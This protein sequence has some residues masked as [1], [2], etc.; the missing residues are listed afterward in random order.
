MAARLLGRY[1]KLLAHMKSSFYLPRRLYSIDASH[2]EEELLAAARYV[3]VLA[4]PG[5]GKTALMGS[6]AQQL[7]TRE[8]TASKFAHSSETSNNV[9]LVIDAF[10]ELAKFDGA[11]IYKVL[12]QASSANP[13]HLYLSS[14]SSEWGI[15]ATNIFEEC[16]AHPPLIVWLYEFSESEQ[17][18]IFEYHVSGEDFSAFRE[19]VARFDLE[20]LL[21]NPQFLKLFAGAYIESGRQF[22]DKR[23][24]FEQAVERLAKES[25]T[26]V[27]MTSSTLSIPQ[28]IDFSSK[29]FAT[30]L[31][32]GAEGV[33]KSEAA[34]DGMYPAL[35]SLCNG[36]IPAD[37]LLATQL[38]RPGENAD[39]HR[40]VHRIVAEYCAA[41]Y[42]TNRIIDPVDPLTR[43]NCLSIIAPNSTVREEL[44]GL[45]AW[46]AALGNK[47]V[48]DAA[49]KLDPFGVLVNG[50]P[51][52]L[53]PSSKRLLIQRLVAVEALDPYFRKGDFRR[54]FSASEFFN[55]D[56]VGEIKPLL[57][58][59]SSGHLRDLVLELLVDSTV[60]Y[61]LK[62]ELRQLALAPEEAESTRRLA[63]RCL[64]ISNECGQVNDLPCLLFEATST[65]L[66]ITAD[67]IKSI[68]PDIVDRM[69][70][71]GFFRLCANIYPNEK[72]F[73]GNIGARY[74]INCLITS[75]PLK[76][77]QWLLDE[78][79]RDLSSASDRTP[80][81]VTYRNGI[82]KV[83][84]SLLDQYFAVAHPPFNPAQIWRWINNLNYHEPMAVDG[85]RAVQ[86]LQQDDKLRQGIFALAFHGISDRDQV[87]KTKRLFEGQCHSGLL[88]KDSDAKWLVDQAF[89]ADNSVLW[90]S[91]L[92][93]P[94]IY[95]VGNHP[96]P[97]MLRRHMRE[98]ASKKKL[99]MR[100]FA[101]I[102]RAI[103]K[104]VGLQRRHHAWRTSAIRRQR[105]KQLSLQKKIAKHIQEKTNCR[106]LERDW[107]SC[108]C[109]AELVLDQ[110]EH[111]Q[112]DVVE[113]ELVRKALRNCLAFIAPHI[114]DTPMF[115]EPV[116]S[117][118]N[119]NALS[120][121][122]ASCLE[123]M[124]FK[125]S[126]E[127]VDLRLI[128]A[129]R[130]SFYWGYS[131]VSYEDDCALKAEAGRL[132]FT[133]QSS[134]ENYLRQYVEPQLARAAWV[135]PEVE[136]LREEVFSDLRARV[137][138]DWLRRFP[139]LVLS[140]TDT[141]FEIAAQYCNRQDLNEFITERCGEL[142]EDWK[143]PT[144]CEVDIND[145]QEFWLVRAWYFLEDAP[146]AFGIWQESGR[147]C[148][149]TLFE[150]HKR[151][152]LRDGRFWPKLTSK[153]AGKIMTT[154][155]DK[156]SEV[157]LS[158]EN[159]DWPNSPFLSEV[160]GAITCENPYD[161]LLVLDRLLEDSR[162]VQM[163]MSLSSL[164]SDVVSK[165]ALQAF[166][167]PAPRDIFAFL[168]R[169][170]IVTVEGLRQLVIQE[171]CNYQQDIIGG[172]YNP[173]KRFYEKGERLDEPRCT[174]I[175]AERLSLK[176]QS[177]NIDVIPEHQL[178]ASKRSDFT[179]GKLIRGK[180]R[181]LVTEVKGQW[182]KK[183]Y[184]AASDQLSRLYAIHPDAEQ[185]GIFLVIWFGPDIEVAGSKK[186]GIRSAEQLRLEIE[187]KLPPDLI[188]L[189]DVFVLDVSVHG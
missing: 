155:A 34:E 13:S 136:L 174:E 16:M 5:A 47:P 19:E 125:G 161:A 185:Q 36:N 82:S 110:P 163:H 52:Q 146:E 70:L 11:S 134:A 118:K 124:R 92:P 186:H 4:E 113:L 8:V 140:T 112:N 126:L 132:I 107:D 139:N 147:R 170:A 74:F 24:I 116:P 98:Q 138:I 78:L 87:I 123:I 160:L 119:Y 129:L 43:E 83:I 25:N 104:T 79:T 158:L 180:R 73:E 176:L 30:L 17:R 156:C 128:K 26:Q 55:R 59:E 141:L 76:E 94:E 178:H 93:Q 65:S 157:N 72:R 67:I 29:V 145:E 177:Q 171:L 111:F 127:S 85:S 173:G 168:D 188:G 148:V 135:Y 12:G 115:T 169:D 181:L 21:P 22:A 64:L 184:E 106:E 45:L 120:I 102:D 46:M 100:E 7:G 6:L 41:R 91:F 88:W 62:N 2:T 86:V 154:L 35:N 77:V 179:V 162:L 20:M 152:N 101:S 40:P 130:A 31:L 39:R 189:I 103:E 14:R 61:Q 75:L 50:D 1:D 49:I 105:R 89:E 182:H 48:A 60:I 167:P 15:A 159:Q 53:H 95:W 66:K 131:A 109:F 149:W 166:V 81:K 37:A 153:K 58:R 175:I 44:R 121:L 122:Y 144:D 150:P 90:G 96:G 80:L 28:K 114:P 3:V 133:D 57:T 143:E 10:D 23:S 164:R 117:Q 33:S 69:D 172:E 151:M 51:S 97:N 42:L 183:L 108:L 18:K 27:G 32:S 63:N 165:I 38:F 137:A 54:R 187:R 56:V 142:M 9:P 68:G 71:L 84:G 99:F